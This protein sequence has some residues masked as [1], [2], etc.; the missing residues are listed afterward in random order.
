MQYLQR[1]GFAVVLCAS[2]IAGPA[3]SQAPPQP[4]EEKAGPTNVK[5]PRDWR[6]N[7]TGYG[8]LT[9][10]SGS[11]SARGQTVDIDA[12]IFKIIQKSDSLLAWDSYFEANKGKL[13][14]YA[15]FV[16][17]KMNIPAS[18][19]AYRNPVAGLQL[20]VSANGAVTPSMTI[21]EAG[22]AYE[23]MKRPGSE[24]SFTALDVF[25]GARY[26]N[27]STQVQ[28]DITGN[29][30]FSRARLVRFDFS[31]NAAVADSGTL[32]WVDPLIGLRLRHQFTA[33]Q[34]IMARGDIGGFGIPGS[35]L[36]S[37]QLVGVYSYAWQFNGYALA[38]VAGYRAL[39]TNINFNPG[40]DT[41]NLNLILHG[42]VI[43]MSVRF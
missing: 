36:F 31:R 34:S 41:S 27:M 28:F 13:G 23:V 40:P 39:S 43:G 8:W 4:A 42:P 6:F 29:V 9:S 37:W 20:S 19:S 18:A 35:S 17:A 3:F 25:A 7:L 21:V 10:M 12:S 14:L 24:D 5:S 26:W 30:D 1:A 2:C 33:N 22:A 11:A 38:A 16:W 32:E 15:D